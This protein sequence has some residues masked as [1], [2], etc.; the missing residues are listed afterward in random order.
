MT[1]IRKGMPA[2]KLGRQEFERRY[3]ARFVDSALAPLQRELDAVI[4][5]AWDTYSH[6]RKAPV[7]RKAGRGFADP[8]YDLTVDWL[9]DMGLV[10]AGLMAEADGY[11]G[12][13]EPYATSH[14][15]LD[16]DE[17]FRQETTHVARAL[18]QAIQ[19]ARA[20][21]L[22]TPGAGLSDPAPK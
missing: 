8:N 1:Q 17:A 19:L 20:G 6:G 5:A 18:G 7:T 22:E 11:V 13:M 14:D 3:R 10:S 15:A 2:V 4:A 21:K 9:T 12:H 16:R